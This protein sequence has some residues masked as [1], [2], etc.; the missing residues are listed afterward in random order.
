VFKLQSETALLWTLCMLHIINSF[1]QAHSDKPESY[2]CWIIWTNR[3]KMYKHFL[4]NKFTDY[5]SWE[6]CWWISE[7]NMKQKWLK[8]AT[9]RKI[10]KQ[11]RAPD[12]I[13]N[14][15]KNTLFI[16]IHFTFHITGIICFFARFVSS[17]RTEDFIIA[18]TSFEYILIL[19]CYF[20]N[21]SP[22]TYMYIVPTHMVFG[23]VG[24]FV[25]TLQSIWICL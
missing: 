21:I 20:D 12:I 14:Y 3:I 7:G 11:S 19:Q 17:L 5:L 13:M 8:D 24:L 18:V 4:Y 1:V 2:F 6:M 22:F 15:L 10:C 25:M 9:W 23:G 16:L